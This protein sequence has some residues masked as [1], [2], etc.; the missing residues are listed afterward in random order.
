MG[1][2]KNSFSKALG[3]LKS[4]KIDEKL[5]VLNEIPTNNTM[6]LYTVVPG[7]AIRVDNLGKVPDHSSIDWD[8]DGS[9]GQDTTGLFDGA[10]NHKFISPPGDNSYIL[11]PMSSMYYTYASPNVWTMIGY[12]RESDRRMVNLGDIDGTLEDW[13]GV[14][15]FTSYG[16][17]TIEQARWFRDTAKKPDGYRAFYPGP[18]SSTPDA[19]GRYYCTITGTPLAQTDD[20]RDRAPID[21]Q[22]SDILSAIL[23]RLNKGKKLSNQEKKWLEDNSVND[24]A[25]K[26]F[27][28][29]AGGESKAEKLMNGLISALGK[30]TNLE[31]AA[32]LLNMYDD[33]L[34]NPP[35]D[36]QRLDATSQFSARDLNKLQSVR[37]QKNI[38]FAINKAIEIANDP[39]RA[40]KLVKSQNKTLG[41]LQ[42]EVAGDRVTTYLQKMAHSTGGLDNSLHNNVQIDREAFRNSGGKDIVII[43]DYQFRPGGSVAGAED[44]AL[45]KALQKGGVELDSVGSGNPLVMIG[46]VV[47]AKTGITGANQ[48]GGLYKSPPMKY[49]VVVPTNSVKGNSYNPRNV[50][51][52]KTLGMDYA[53]KGRV[54]SESRRNRILKTL[55]DPVVIPETKQKSYKVDPGRRYKKDKTN[56]QGMDKLVGDVTPQKSFKKP[57]DLWSDGWQGHNARVSQ[58]KKNIVL[59]KIGQGKQAWNY[60]LNHSQIMNADQLENFW[61]KNPD[62]YSISL[63]VRNIDLLEKSKLKEIML[64]S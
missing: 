4:T 47:A 46:A 56:F 50:T 45:G 53:P 32:N 60:M 34:K 16:Q 17:L 11:G 40:N 43:K 25:L 48:H 27:N 24:E 49:K 51:R 9:N 57:Q 14:S 7:T 64:Y 33:F 21:L 39:N 22:S 10:G 62:F 58:D 1:R 23:D 18:P 28:K 8:I 3:H 2:K 36:G 41:D 15:N 54:L 31:S 12:I 42:W 52:F 6:S 5:E 55:K 35:P 29:W 13:D 19:F 37:N 20:L 63:M 59:E 30:I 61:G 44:T 38:N 26:S